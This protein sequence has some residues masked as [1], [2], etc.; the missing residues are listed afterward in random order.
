MHSNARREEYLIR[1]FRKDWII[2]LILFARN[3]PAVV[4]QTF[5]MDSHK[6]ADAAASEGKNLAERE[7]FEP[8]VRFPVHL[9][10]REQLKNNG[11]ISRQKLAGKNNSP[12]PRLLQISV[13]FCQRFFHKSFT[14]IEPLRLITL[15]SYQVHRS[16]YSSVLRIFFTVLLLCMFA[17]GLCSLPISSNWSTFFAD[18]K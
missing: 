1:E 2:R 10:S 6:T 12:L 9:I 5:E 11:N 4:G 14:L 7:G 15:T 16:N 18:G 17:Q 3:K 13:S 8:P